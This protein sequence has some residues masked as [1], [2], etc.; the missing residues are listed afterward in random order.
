MP[1]LNKNLIKNNKKAI[2]IHLAIIG[3]TCIFP[4]ILAP[5]PNI[6][7]GSAIIYAMLIFAITLYV[8][9]AQ[10]L[11]SS[12]TLNNLIS[13]LSP[14]FIGFLLWLLCYFSSPKDMDWKFGQGGIWLLYELYNYGSMLIYALIEERFEI[15]YLN[16]SAL[17]TTSFLP[18][19]VIFV[20][21]QLK[22]NIFKKKDG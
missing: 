20:G 22:R 19:V 7:N 2:F 4:A 15:E 12:S 18:T 11:E 5:I 16:P 6:F 8:C 10:F 9:G 13:C 1:L 14:S 21:L 17:M 3:L